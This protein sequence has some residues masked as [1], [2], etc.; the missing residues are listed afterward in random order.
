MDPSGASWLCRDDISR[1]RLLDM[2]RRLKPMRRAT[3]VVLGAALIACGP[4]IGWWPL[5]AMAIAASGFAVAGGLIDRL[6]HP[7]YAAAGAW[8]MAQVTIAISI[9]LSGA[10]TSPAVGWLAIPVVTLSARFDRRVV[11]AGLLLTALLML[12]VTIGAGS[13]DVAANPALAIAPLALLAAVGLLSTALMTSDVEHRSKSVLDALTGMLNRAS[14]EARAAELRQQAELTREPVG[15]I[16]GDIDHFKPINDEHGHTVGDAVLVDVA[17]AMRTQL[18]AFD[19]AYRIGG[20]EFLVLLPGAR[21]ADAAELAERLR[22]AVQSAPA[23]G[24]LRVTMSFGVTC[25][26]AGEFDY[27]EV[28]AAADQALYSA[29]RAGRNR[30]HLSGDLQGLGLA[31]A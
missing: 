24:G 10:A 7:E 27:A 6:R 15:V 22:A 26:N 2:D 8:V 13:G 23:A 12:G 25:S 19:L 9:A 18:R 28:F 4:W 14:L 3:F 29:K 17:A 5:T 20:E 1:S 11:A 16:V 30:V 21:L 31:A